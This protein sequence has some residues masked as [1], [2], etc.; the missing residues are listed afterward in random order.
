MDSDGVTE[1]GLNGEL[2]FG[3]YTQQLDWLKAKDV[4]LT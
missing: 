1:T 3:A 2:G 4:Y